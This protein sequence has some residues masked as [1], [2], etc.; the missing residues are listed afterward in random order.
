[1][2]LKMTALLCIGCTLSSLSFAQGILLNHQDLRTDLNWLNQQGV[3][4]LSTSTWPL[5]GNDVQRAL[6]QANIQNATQQK[7]VNAILNQLK[8]ENQTLRAGLF[9][10]T[11]DPT[12]PQAFADTENARHQASLQFNLGNEHWD[13]RL[14]LNAEKDPLMT[15]DKVNLEGSYVAGK[16]WNQWLIAGQIPTWW[17]AAHDGSLIRGDASRPVYGV[18]VQRDVQHAFETK[19]LS[20][21]GEWQYQ[22]FA[23]QLQDY[24]A[25]P[26][27]KLIGLRVTARPF[28][29]L[30]LGASRMLQWGGQGRPESLS[31][32]KDAILGNKDNV[33]ESSLELSNQLA[34]IDFSLQ[35]NSLLNIPAR[36]YAQN[37]G[38][39]EAGGLPAKK[40]Y[41][42]GVDFS[43]HYRNM[44]YQL[45]AEW[46]DTRTNG[47]TQGISYNHSIYT[48][49][50]YQQGFP[51]AH[52]MGG[53]GEMLSTGGDIRI[54]T[55]NRLSGRILYAKVNQSG[56]AT[57]HAFPTQDT[58]KGLDVTWTHYIQ[59]NI[60]LK[61]SGWFSDSDLNG[62]D[63]GLAVGVEFPLDLKAIKF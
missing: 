12:L 50:F 27:T 18:T 6:A 59:P 41:L 31:S 9:A 48:D 3:I 49:G 23:G 39:D 5:S 7:V 10:S 52:A 38:E 57:N 33:H 35:L 34:G 36:V 24:A 20:W 25:I 46:A 47:K 16:V 32:L 2:S 62:K 42:A 13:A 1:M 19:W 28:A 40:M 21:I 30:E 55:M 53:D 37:I 45:Y 54:D 63:H 43:S 51:L 4:E 58:L 29:S 44:P 22:A 8:A 17:G 11:D 15:D 26:D 56:R 14:Q 61:F 60:P